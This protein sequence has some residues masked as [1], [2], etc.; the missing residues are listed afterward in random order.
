MCWVITG[1]SI[2]GVILNVYKNRWGFFF[3]MISNAGWVVVDYI[4]GIPEQS[5]L[6]C[7][8]FLTS[9]WGWVAWSKQG[10]QK[11]ECHEY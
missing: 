8:Y 11:G 2:L 10:K 9:L 4:K 5:V 3:W 1:I 7:V 6:F